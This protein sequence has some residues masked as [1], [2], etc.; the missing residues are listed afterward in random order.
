MGTLGHR[1][2]ARASGS[3]PP[4]PQ[5]Q[6]GPI[7]PAA[8]TGPPWRQPAPAS[9]P[10]GGVG[11]SW[12]VLVVGA[13]LT[14]LTTALLLARA[15]RSVLV[16]EARY[17]G[18]GTTGASTAKVSLLQ[19]SR[20]GSIADRHSAETVRRY[21]GANA[22]GQAWLRRFCGDHGVAWQDRPAY[23]YATTDGGARTARRELDL[24]R[25]AGL[26]VEWLDEVPLPF[27]THGAVRLPGQGQVD[28]MAL[29]TRL[30]EQAQAHGARV[31]EGSRVR[32][33]TGHRPLRVLTETG[34]A[35]AHAVVVATNLPFLDRGG[36]F[37]AA[38]AQRSY[39]LAFT[40]PG[41][42]VDGM[43]LSVDSPTRSLRDAPAADGGHLLL[44]GGNGHAT[45]RTG[46]H[47]ARLE[48]L[49]AWTLEHFPGARRTHAWSAQDYAPASRLPWAG[50][51][52]PGRGDL[53]VAGG[54]DKWGMANAV[55]ASLA[56]ASRLLGGSRPDWAS[57]FDPWAP[58]RL[59]A[60]PEAAWAN[61]E[62]GL[63]LGRGWLRP[64]A[65]VGSR[66]APLEGRG[67]VR[68]RGRR[69]PVAEATVAGRTRRVSAV[70]PHLGGI[71]TWN[72][73]EC[74]W[75]CPLHGSRFTV[76]GRVLEG[77]AARGLAEQ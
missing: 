23:S 62:V 40:T 12:D 38:T 75:D 3:R 18:A 17:A 13:G 66:S 6:E 44:V 16:V 31:V 53:L 45:G 55:A 4:R 57:V 26:P 58:S 10:R 34:S 33:V 24:A 15:G 69:P 54:Y 1:S 42:A 65:G 29:V 14:G 73:A 67:R 59:L 68:H 43:Y 77:P 70:C 5:T 71:V 60:A 28:P 11:G 2:T 39:A 52:L 22:E 64:L 9:E 56:V 35:A 49:E 32:R 41:P 50:G 48:D 72:D 74:S 46:R 30:R 47:A 7:S 63:H 21:L 37:A 25:A 76:D 36:Y 20:L 27:P 19:G 8:T 61:L 51:L